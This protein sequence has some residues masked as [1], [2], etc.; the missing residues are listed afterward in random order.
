M[1]FVVL[2]FFL[3]CDILYCEENGGL[4]MPDY[5][6][7]PRLPGDEENE[8][9]KRRFR[10]FDSQREGKGVTKEDAKITPDLG[11]FFRSFRRN[12]SKLLSV[13][14][15]TLIGNFPLLFAI[16]ALSGI[17]KVAYMTP[18]SGYFADLRVLMLLEGARDPATMATIG[19]LGVQITNTAMTTTS[20]IFFAISALTL[21]TFGFTKVGTTYIIRALIRGEPTF[22][23]SDFKYAIKK[24]KKQA[25]LYGILDL[26]FLLLI[27]INVLILFEAAGGF[28]NSVFLWTNVLLA[29]LYFFMRPYIYLQMITFDLRLIKILKNSL[30]FALLG[31]KRNFMALLGFVLLVLLMI[32]LIFG[33]GGALLPLGL[34]IPMVLLF[35]LGSFMGDFAAWFKIREIMIDP[36]PAEDH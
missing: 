31:F 26:V 17:T 13:N 35:S 30:I 16:L 6:N 10:L 12:F 18:L 33:I 34:A 22:M 11:G 8:P 32:F 23:L 28:L 29:I 5:M 19:A 25:F 14:L 9:K 20:Y 24:N 7:D 2:L 36:K 27:P 4:T 3:F 1:F 15:L 21:F